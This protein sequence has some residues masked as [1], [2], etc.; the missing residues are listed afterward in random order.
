MNI[1]RGFGRAEEILEE[2]RLEKGNYRKQRNVYNGD[3]LYAPHWAVVTVT[4]R[5]IPV[6]PLTV[7]L[8]KCTQTTTPAMY[9]CIIY[10]S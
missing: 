6:L 3:T 10:M 8:G 2:Q 1:W 7:I 5:H 4:N 9:V